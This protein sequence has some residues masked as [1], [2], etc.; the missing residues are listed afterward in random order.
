M[1]SQGSSHRA[2]TVIA[3]QGAGC[4]TGAEVP[5]MAALAAAIRRCRY[6]VLVSAGCTLGPMLCRAWHDSLRQPVGTVIVIQPCS[7]TDRQGDGPATVLGPVRTQHDLITLCRW[8]HAAQL[9]YR[10]LP[11]R[12]RTVPPSLRRAVL[13]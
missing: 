7:S 12:L 3:C 6:G 13:N 5:V 2:F 4:R 9:D 10:A 11:A 1:S 8:L